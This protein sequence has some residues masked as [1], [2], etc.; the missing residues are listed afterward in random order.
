MIIDEKLLML[1]HFVAHHNGSREDLAEYMNISSRQLTRLLKKW[2][3]QNIIEYVAGEGRGNESTIL[4]K[5][6]VE[7]RFINEYL[8]TINERSI[9]DID[10][11]L[12]LPLSKKSK[13]LI[14]SVVQETLY[15]YDQSNSMKQGY[16]YTDTINYIPESFHPLNESDHTI[17][18][19]VLN[20]MSRLYE[21]D[22]YGNLNP[23][24]VI[25]DEWKDNTLIIHLLRTIKFSDGRGLFAEDVVCCLKQLFDRSDDFCNV[26]SVTTAG[27]YTL[28]IE[29]NH[30]TDSIKYLLSNLDASIYREEQGILLTTG[31]Y[32]VAKQNEEMMTLRTNFFHFKGEHDI[33]TLY[34][35]SDQKK[36]QLIY[37]NQQLDNN[38]VSKM[39]TKTMLL[40]NPYSR[41]NILQRMYL[42]HLILA[43]FDK[44]MQHDSS[45][46]KRL[47]DSYKHF[48]GRQNPSEQVFTKPVRILLL[49]IKDNEQQM[50]D[51]L[52]TRGVPV[53]VTEDEF[54]TY[55]YTNLNYYN[56]DMVMTKEV[57]PA[58]LS[59]Y[60]RLR[61]G[62]FKEWYYNLKESRQLIRIYMDKH[63]QYWTYAEQRYERFLAQQALVIPISVT[64]RQFSF[65]ENFR[66][67]VITQQG[68]IDYSKIIVKDNEQVME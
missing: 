29:M 30:Q 48:M 24:L 14:T 7:Q 35:V 9:S 2:E 37:Q 20:T 25:Y 55:M 50:V 11:I 18:T 42:T 36:Y 47:F 1:N 27:V 43:F 8:M 33:S 51:Y 38:K 31:P 53:E 3:E 4:F 63:S 19:I 61:F 60:Q 64:A 56:V 54:H 28:A 5:V 58:D 44:T 13:N 39:L 12:T 23:E 15:T 49:G 26:V 46:E 21:L 68:L 22:S 32:Y 10:E 16:I 62:K 34:L 57:I 59:Y 67:I 41:V 17:D 65:P 6:D 52:K 45:V 40:F 66:N